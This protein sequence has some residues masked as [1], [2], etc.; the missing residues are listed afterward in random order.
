MQIR[1]QMAMGVKH[2]QYSKLARRETRYL[3]NEE[4][5]RA[6]ANRKNQHESS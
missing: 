3:N 2:V 6:A 1:M 5:K 4:Y